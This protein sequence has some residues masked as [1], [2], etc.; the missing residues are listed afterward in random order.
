MV[1]LDVNGDVRLHTVSLLLAM[2]LIEYALPI[3]C[4]ALCCVAYAFGKLN[5]DG[6][7]VMQTSLQYIEIEKNFM[8]DFNIIEFFLEISVVVKCYFQM[9]RRTI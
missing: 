6:S 8:I 7:R 4:C 2:R 1:T 5:K 9:C 3:S